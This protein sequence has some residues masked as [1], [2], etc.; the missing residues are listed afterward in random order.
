MKTVTLVLITEASQCSP[1]HRVCP[2]VYQVPDQTSELLKLTELWYNH[3]GSNTFSYLMTVAEQ[4]FPELRISLL[5]LFEALASQSWAQTIMAN[6]PGFREYLLDRSTEK[7]KECK[8]KKYNVVLTLVNA[9]TTAEIFG[10]P[11]LVQLKVYCNQGP[12]FV[13]VQAE[14]AM[15][16]DS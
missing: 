9:P 15:E 14:V 4:P 16:G 6:H 10:N 5:M 12:F 1:V 7:V 3:L 2:H 11:Y 13:R 8:E